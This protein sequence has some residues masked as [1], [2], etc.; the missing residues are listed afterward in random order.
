MISQ[1]VE[2]ALRAVV[3]LS[4]FA[5]EARTTEEIAEHTKVP[6]AYLSKVLQCLSRE[7]V[8][9]TQRG[10]GGGI[11]LVKKPH[12]LT[13]LEVINAVEPMNRIKRCPLGIPMHGTQLCALHRKLDNALATIEKAF[14]DT[15]FADIIHE[16]TISAPLCVLPFR[17][18][19]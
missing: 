6:R 16:R 8:V 15:T 12:E 2:Y 18:R 1:S 5:P 4:Q 17:H 10:I 19:A 3:H 14:A 7:K 9:L 13:M 11:S